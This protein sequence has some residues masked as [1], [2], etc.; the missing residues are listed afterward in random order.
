MS[1]EAS[2]GDGVAGGY[3]PPDMGAGI[4]TLVLGRHSV[5]I[6][7]VPVPLTFWESLSFQLLLLPGS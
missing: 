7:T 5:C 4:L 1:P 2:D 3:E 6:S